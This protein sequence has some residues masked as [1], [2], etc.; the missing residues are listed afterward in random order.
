MVFSKRKM[1]VDDSKPLNLELNDMDYVD[2]FKYLG[3][4]IISKRG[5]QFSAKNDLRCF[6]RASN[7][8]FDTLNKPNDGIQMKLLYT[9]CVPILTHASAAE[10]YESSE[11]YD[12]NAALNNA[13]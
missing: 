1:S 11:F 5:L 13:F 9:N 4:T 3:N 7:A 8:I 10:E 6:S 2:S 12:C